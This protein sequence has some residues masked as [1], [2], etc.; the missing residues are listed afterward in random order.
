MDGCAWRMYCISSIVLFSAC[1]DLVRS[2]RFRL[3]CPV[4]DLSIHFIRHIRSIFQL[5]T[6]SSVRMCEIVRAADFSLILTVTIIKWKWILKKLMAEIVDMHASVSVCQRLFM[7]VRKRSTDV[8]W[9]R[10]VALRLRSHYYYWS[11]QLNLSRQLFLRADQRWRRRTTAMSP[12]FS[13]VCFSPFNFI[14]L[15]D[16]KFEFESSDV[17]DTSTPVPDRCLFR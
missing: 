13:R 6:T 3:G 8:L 17:Y 5:A 11:F 12:L 2:V 15:V 14:C 9:S 1:G 7:W 4:R 10:A 16:S